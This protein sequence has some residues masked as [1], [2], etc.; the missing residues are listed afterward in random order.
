MEFRASLH[1]IY[2]KYRTLKL[3]LPRK[4]VLHQKGTFKCSK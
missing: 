3:R 4:K 1:L 2:K